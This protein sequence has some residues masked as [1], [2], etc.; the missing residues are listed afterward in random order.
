MWKKVG[1]VIII[2]VLGA[3]FKPGINGLVS[4]G[5]FYIQKPDIIVKKGS[6]KII[7]NPGDPGYKEISHHALDMI[8]SYNNFYSQV[9]NTFSLVVATGTDM[10]TI[11]GDLSYVRLT[12]NSPFGKRI[13]VVMIDPSSHYGGQ[14][15]HSK[16][17][18]GW[19]AYAAKDPEDF[20]ILLGMMEGL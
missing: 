13:Y 5:I 20:E 17:G 15:Y 3:L 2:L 14:I 18:D 16:T 12:A 11:A 9:E 10:D 4:E 8:Y 7:L 1:I 6:E 19:R